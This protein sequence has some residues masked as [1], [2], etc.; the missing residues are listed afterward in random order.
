MTSTDYNGST[1]Y[2][3]PGSYDVMLV[4]Y[5]GGGSCAD[6]IVKTLVL[7]YPSATPAIYGR[8]DRCMGDP[9]DTIIVQNG[10]SYQWVGGD[11][12]SAGDSVLV[13][14]PATDTVVR[15]VVTSVAGCTDTLAL[16]CGATQPCRPAP[17]AALTP[18]TARRWQGA[19]ARGR[20]I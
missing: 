2:T 16:T 13:L 8:T 11:S 3:S 18:Y 4:S 15:C 1:V 14:A 7:E 12:A 10:V 19:T 5:L 6:T 20:W 17:R 9:A